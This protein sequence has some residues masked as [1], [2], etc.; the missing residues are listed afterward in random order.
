[1]KIEVNFVDSHGQSEVAFAFC[2]LLGFRLTVKPLAQG[3][4]ALA[5]SISGALLSYSPNCICF[6][7][8]VLVMLLFWKTKN[9]D[10]NVVYP[11]P[12]PDLPITVQGVISATSS[13]YRNNISKV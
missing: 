7:M 4:L 11:S 8:P 9:L 6:F 13:G 3:G 12:F 10:W 5:I 2:H 1:M